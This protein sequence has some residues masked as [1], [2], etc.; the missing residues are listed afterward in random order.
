[1]RPRAFAIALYFAAL[2]FPATVAQMDSPDPQGV[3]CLQY[4]QT[5]ARL[6][7]DETPEW[8]RTFGIHPGVVTEAAQQN[9]LVQ[10]LKDPTFTGGPNPTHTKTNRIYE[11]TI[12]WSAVAQARIFKCYLRYTRTSDESHWLTFDE[13]PVS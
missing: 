2:G 9:L 12:G 1:V 6:L 4:L 10:L 11:V 7:L 3:E 13:R 5:V 8:V